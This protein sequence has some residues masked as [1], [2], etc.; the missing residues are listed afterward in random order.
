MGAVLHYRVKNPW[1]SLSFF[2]K[3]FNPT[4]QKYN[5]YDRELL[6]IY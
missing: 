1:L 5:A 2:S 4:Q 6:A 3:K